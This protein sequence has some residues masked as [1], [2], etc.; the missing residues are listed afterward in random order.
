MT[1]TVPAGY[2]SADAEQDVVVDNAATCEQDPYVGET[3][4]FD[5]TP[6]TN[7]T[8]TVTGQ[9]D[10]GTASTISCVDEAAEVVASLPLTVDGGN[11]AAND[12]EPQ[13]I[14]CTIVIDP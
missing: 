11:A 9:V 8:V 1:E 12:L 6:L 5:N 7:L 3:V 2:V 14:V 13:T 10:G 4:N